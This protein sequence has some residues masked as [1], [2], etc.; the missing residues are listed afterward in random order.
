MYLIDTNIVIYAL[1]GDEQVLTHFQRTTAEPKTVSVVTYG[2]LLY[3]AMKSQRRQENLAKVRRLR[4][5]FPIVEATNAIMETYA[6]IKAEI[7]NRGKPLDDFDLVIAAT[8]ICLGYRLVTNNERHFRQIE[9]LQIENW[10]RRQNSP[11]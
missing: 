5:I 1:K 6:S 8:A 2:E 7:E 4:E 10:T 11:R 9:G 3:G